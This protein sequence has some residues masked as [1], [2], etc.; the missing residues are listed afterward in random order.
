MVQIQS[1][2]SLASATG[3]EQK[4]V[5]SRKSTLDEDVDH[6]AETDLHRSLSTRHL[7]MIALGSAIGMGLWLGSGTSLQKGGPAALVI[8][9]VL[10]GT[11]VW[12]VSQ[13]IGEMAVLYPLPSA[14][15]QW[16]QIFIDPAVAFTLGWAY[17]IQYFITVA[18]ELQGFVTTLN[19]WT[20]KVPTPAAIIIAWAI[21]VFINVWAVRFF[22]EVEVC[23][24]AIKF[25][26]IIVVI[27]SLIVISAGGSPGEGPIGFRYW[28]I[29]PFTNGFKGFLSVLPICIFAMSGSENIALVAA[30]T[31]QP[32]TAVPKAVNSIWLRLSLFYILGSLA[33]T[34]NVDPQNP[35]LFGN[36]GSNASPFV[37]AYK[38]A[39]LMPLAH[40]MNAVIMI[41][42]LSTGSISAYAGARTLMG[43]AHIN[44]APKIF[45]RA[46]DDGR[47]WAGV[48]STLII[49]GGISFLNVSSSGAEVFTW[50]SNLTSLFVLFGWGI[51]CLSHIRM[52]YAWVAQGR[53][54]SSLAWR[55]RW[56]PFS[57]YWGLVWCV[58]LMG[59]EFYL[60]VWPLHEASSVSNFFA[61]Y[62]SVVAVI[63]IYAA[64]KLFYRT[65][66]WIEGTKVDLDSMRRF[67]RTDTGAGRPTRDKKW[68]LS[69]MLSALVD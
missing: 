40:M 43:L 38:S 44:M 33:V 26:W 1:E 64:A 9:Y 16:A 30:E 65:P 68:R 54:L 15:V 2:V 49:G 57:A 41:S 8:G 53:P 46:D 62:V 22:G 25:F 39:G 59:L 27:I 10:S 19:F 5:I 47:P 51:I 12:A 17:W 7:T 13:S 56:F 52:R 24:S 20:D 3:P 58:V 60:S 6:G 61:N 67:Y 32:R 63:V 55:S 29:A 31:S 23:S 48:L 14:F 28:N 45:G 34:I 69:N 35:D 4:K 11:M 66:F 50:F 36:S 21:I 42:V 37:L 18:N